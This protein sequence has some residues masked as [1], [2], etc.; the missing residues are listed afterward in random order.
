MIRDPAACVRL[1]LR[2]QARRDARLLARWRLRL[3]AALIASIAIGVVFEAAV[4]A[5]TRLP[6]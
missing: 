2:Q 3:E 5:L 1:R 4:G 6:A